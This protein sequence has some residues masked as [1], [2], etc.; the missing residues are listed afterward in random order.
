MSQNNNTTMKP[1]QPVS[2]IKAMLIGAAIGLVA[3]SY[4]V[5]GVDQPSMDWGKYWMV[6]PL[7]AVP[8]AGAAG[9]L[10]FSFLQHL[11]FQGALNKL[12]G[13]IIGVVGF[14]VIMWL[15][16]VFGLNGTMWN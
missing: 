2:L 8:I 3:I 15:G 5:F 7:I 4:F 14:I 11:S 10:F 13:I 16:I 9:G 12:L 1:Y 6:K